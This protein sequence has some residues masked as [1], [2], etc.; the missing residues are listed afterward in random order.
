[1]VYNLKHSGISLVIVMLLML[2]DDILINFME[3]V[4]LDLPKFIK[5]P[6]QMENASQF[7]WQITKIK[8]TTQ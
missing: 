1:M 8:K 3:H 7:R 5:T 4:V 6:R 2:A